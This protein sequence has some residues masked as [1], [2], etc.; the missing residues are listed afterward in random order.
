MDGFEINSHPVFFIYVGEEGTD[1]D[2]L[3]K[4]KDLSKGAAKKKVMRPQPKLDLE[5]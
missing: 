5:R 4:L 2:V 1:A 3:S